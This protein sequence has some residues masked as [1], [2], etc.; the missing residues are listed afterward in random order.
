MQKQEVLEWVLSQS[1]I[2][3]YKFSLGTLLIIHRGEKQNVVTC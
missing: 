2:H 1:P 3:Q